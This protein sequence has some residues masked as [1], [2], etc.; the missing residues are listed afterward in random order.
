MFFHEYVKDLEREEAAGSDIGRNGRQLKTVARDSILADVYGSEYRQQQ[1]Y[2]AKHTEHCRWGHRWW[3][4]ASCDGMG[5]VLLASKEFAE[6][7]CN[8]SCL[9]FGSLIEKKVC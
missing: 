4:I 1:R 7:M 8:L 2:R 3:R 5:V 9:S 6:E